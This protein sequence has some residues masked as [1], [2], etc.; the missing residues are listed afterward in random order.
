MFDLE[1]MPD[2]KQL[3][4]PQTLLEFTWPVLQSVGAA[5]LTFV[6]GR[7]LAKLIVKGLRAAMRRG[8]VDDTLA[9]FLGKV[10]NGLLLAVIVVTALGELGVNTTSASALLG[11]AALAIGLSLQGQLSSLAAGVMLIIFRPFKKG[12]LVDVGGKVGTVDHINIISTVLTNLE[13]QV[14]TLPNSS[15]FGNTIINITSQP[16]RRL[17]LTVGVSYKSDLRKAKLILE[18]LLAEDPRVLS[19]PPAMVWVKDLA[20][21]SVNF[22][23][24]PCIATPDFWPTRCELI[25]QIKLRFDAAGIEIPYRQLDLHLRDAAAPLAP[26]PA[27]SDKALPKTS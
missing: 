15:V 22:A 2:F 10:A 3:S 6:I 11:G 8:K 4:D 9:E 26:P 27:S 5:L 19:D 17:D 1:K 13:N 24:R 25:E 7:L 14:V 23:V 12:D 20:E 21:S 18:E 16:W